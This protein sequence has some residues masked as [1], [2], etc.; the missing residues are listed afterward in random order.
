MT[1]VPLALAAVGLLAVAGLRR[2]SAARLWT[3]EDTDALLRAH[4]ALR[5]HAERWARAAV[6]AHKVALLDAY[7]RLPPDE[8]DALRRSIALSWQEEGHPGPRPLF[9]ARSRHEQ[10]S[11]QAGGLSLYPYLPDLAEDDEVRVFFVEPEDVALDS[12]VPHPGR[13]AWRERIEAWDPPR[14]DRRTGEPLQRRA[15][16][17]PRELRALGRSALFTD[18]YGDAERELILRRGV[19]PTRVSLEEYMKMKVRL[20]ALNQ[21]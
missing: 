8:L 20:G 9:R 18:Q 1:G 14:Y 15:A 13:Q 5:P 21:G 4:T 19:N 7:D 6:G 10:V 17:G 2:G 11:P 16:L 12:M 3:V